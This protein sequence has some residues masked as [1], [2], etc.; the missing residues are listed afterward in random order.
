MKPRLLR[1]PRTHAG[2]R[3]LHSAGAFSRFTAEELLNGTVELNRELYEARGRKVVCPPG[4]R[5]VSLSVHLGSRLHP[6]AMPFAIVDEED[7]ARIAAHSWWNWARSGCISAVAHIDGTRWHMARFVLGISHRYVTVRAKA[8][9]LDYRKAN[10][11]T[12]GR[13]NRLPT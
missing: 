13:S 4:A 6:K 8:G 12:E 11:F 2:F 1:D 9:F 5:L 10:L 3:V 7:Y